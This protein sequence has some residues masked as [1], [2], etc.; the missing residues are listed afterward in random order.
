MTAKTMIKAFLAGAF[1]LFLSACSQEAEQTIAPEAP[2]AQNDV[3]DSMSGTGGEGLVLYREHCALCH[4]GGVAKA[5]HVVTLQMARPEM[6]LAAM[7]DGIMEQQASALTDDQRILLAE[8][9]SQQS[10]GSSSA[11]KPVLMCEEGTSLFDLGASPSHSGWGLAPGNTRFVGAQTAGLAPADIPNL[12]LKWAFAYPDATRARSQPAIAGGAVFV[13]SQDGTIY[14]LDAETGCARWT[15]K[16]DSEV[17]SAITIEDWDAD[18]ESA[19]PSAYFGDFNGRVYA[20][21]AVTGALIW[22]VLV[23]EHKDILITGSPKLHGGRLYVPMSSNEWASAADPGYECCTFRGGVAALDA[24][25]GKQIWKSYSIPQEPQLTG[26]L[27]SAGTPR[28]HPAGAPS[29]NSPTIDEARGRLYVGTGEAYTSPAAA[30]SDSIIAM[31]LETGA[32]E[33]S[34]QGT[35]GDAWNMACTIADKANCPVENGPDLDFGAP[36]ILTTLENGKQVI[37][38]GQKAGVVHALDPDADGKLLWKR[39]TGIGG[40]AGGVHWGMAAEGG[41]LFVPNADTYFFG[42]PRGVPKPG[43]FAL[44]AGDGAV[45]WFTPAPNTCPEELKPACDPGLSAAITAIPG[46]VFAG[47]FD[48]RLRAYDSATGK[49]TWEFDTMREFMTINGDIAKGGSIESDGPVISGGKLFINSGYL[50]GSRVGGN[51]LLVFKPSP[52]PALNAD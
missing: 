2:A 47:G 7:N 12:T 44:E 51:V 48:G 36:P 45:K 34:Y 25:T 18:N 42:E 17:R 28:W 33:W 35:A 9:L 15:F 37:L 14:A 52:P 5:P 40:F 38:A 39:Q 32:I 6:I 1:A 21:S 24:R 11:A 3:I 13:G 31:N 30:T 10:L 41:T 50:Y 20:I 26:T 27:N 23:D 29:W 46:A 16:A 22:K 19:Q 43:L 8:F 49:V 4:E